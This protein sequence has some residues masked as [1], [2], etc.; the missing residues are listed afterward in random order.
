MFKT[1]ITLTCA[2]TM[3]AAGQSLGVDIADPTLALGTTAIDPSGVETLDQTPT[4]TVDGLG[5]TATT[6]ASLVDHHSLIFG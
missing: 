5:V 2:L 4:T 3:I 1:T 6:E